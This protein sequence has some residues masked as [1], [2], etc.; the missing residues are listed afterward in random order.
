MIIMP[1]KTWLDRCVESV[2]RE[3]PDLSE[4]SAWAICQSQ[5]K[6]LKKKKKSKAEV[7]TEED[8]EEIQYE[9]LKREFEEV[10]KEEG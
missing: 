10:Y 9:I 2:L 4:D 8:L 1:G 7:F 3:N 6:K 5:Y